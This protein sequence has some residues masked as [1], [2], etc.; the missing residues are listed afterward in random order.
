MFGLLFLNGELN[1]GPAVRAVLSMDAATPLI[2][3]VDGGLRHTMSLGLSP[4]IV[5]GDMDSADPVLLAEVEAHGAEIQRYPAEKDE[6][7]F[8]LGLRLAVARGCTT[9]RVI[10]AMGDRLDQ[11]ISNLYLLALPMLRGC[12]VRLVS[13]VQTTWL[14]YPGTTELYGQVGD[15]VSLIPMAGEATD[16]VTKALAYPLRRETLPFGPAR[17]VSNVMQSEHAAV[18]FNTGLLLV[19]HTV[20]R[21]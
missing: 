9:I 12:D 4:H 14:A 20:G 2:V 17:G 6:T 19:I 11:T 13:G 10:G 8:E 3:A 5:I 18:T 1:D 15:T 21:A 16:I 7:D